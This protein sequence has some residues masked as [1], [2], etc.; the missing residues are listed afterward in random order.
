MAVKN[1]GDGQV[2]LSLVGTAP[3][4]DYGF[5]TFGFDGAVPGPTFRVKPGETLAINFKNDLLAANN[6]GCETTAGEFCEAATTNLHTHGLHI[7]SKGVADGLAANSDDVL[8][9]IAPGASAL[10]RFDI[11]QY[12]M[13]GTHWY[14]PHHHHATALQAGG[15]AA[16]LLIVDDPPG[17]LPTAYESMEEKVLFISGHNLDTLQTMAR[18]AQAGVLEQAFT[19]AQAAGLPANV[20]LVNGQSLPTLTID[21]NT[22]YRLRMVFAAVEQRLQLSTTGDARCTL[23]LLAKDG[24]Y[25]ETIPRDITTIYLYP[26]ARADVAFS[27]TCTTYPCSGTLQSG[28]GAA[29]G[30][31][32]GARTSAGA[33]RLLQRPRPPPPPGPGAG[34][35][36]IDV[37]LFTVNRGTSISTPILET[38]TP[39]RPCYLADL[40]AAVADGTGTI[41]LNGGA[42]TITYNGVGR[43]MT[44][45]NVHS[46]GTMR[47]WPPMATL[48]VGKVYQ[49]TVGVGAH[50]LHVHVNPFQ[51]TGMPAA[52]YGGGYFLVGDWHDTLMIEEA[53]GGTV[54]VK[55]QTDAFTGKV[56]VH[57][58]ILEHE[59]E[60]MMNVMEIIGTEGTTYQAAESLDNTCYRTAFGSSQSPLASSS[61]SP[62]PSPSPSPS[63][64]TLDDGCDNGVQNAGEGGIDCG[65]V[66]GAVQCEVSVETV[67]NLPMTVDSFDQ[68]EQTK[69]RSAVASAASVASDK[70]RITDVREAGGAP[71]SHW[72]ALAASIDVTTEIDVDSVPVSLTADRLAF[73]LTQLGLPAGNIT[74]TPS[75]RIGKRKELPSP[76]PSSPALTTSPPPAGNGSPSPSPSLAILGATVSRSISAQPAAWSLLLVAGAVR[77]VLG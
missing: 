15:G 53:G 2:D 46:T 11:P 77:M 47:D 3:F 49:W 76:L 61:P 68:P 10:Y 21:G 71:Q 7:S 64:S 39:L 6:V 29:A 38:F 48:E 74:Q 31:T 41:A 26:G 59:D 14:H 17:Y 55:T 18:S 72:H 25:L 54:T 58:H 9:N 8:V 12:H 5:D 65:G 37:M 4:V 32:A 73:E 57:C 63:P 34:M 36:E 75:I 62:L 19:T 40:R 67:V 60:G 13:G 45:A 70:V 56:V 1:A 22:W 27:C 52:E 30:A 50:P 42:R 24:V 69:F 51:I 33:R 43:S 23:K 16:G 44:Y 28:A 35:M 20:L 66:C